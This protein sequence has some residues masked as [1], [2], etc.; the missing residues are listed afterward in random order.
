MAAVDANDPAVI[1][2]QNQPPAEGAAPEGGTPP[3]GGGLPSE[4]GNQEMSPWE[5]AKAEGLL[6][7]DFKEDAYE[8]AKSWKSGQEFVQEANAEKA[9]AGQ[10]AKKIE[11][12]ENITAEVNKMLPD[13]L[14]NG[15]ELT[16]EMEEKATELGVDIRDLK[17]GAIELR[18][19]I[20]AAHNI[21]GGQET[22]DSMIADM[23]EVMSEAQQAEF[24]K[25]VT[26]GMSEWA[27][28]GLYAEWK[29]GG[30]TPEGKGR[31]E[32]RVKGGSNAKPYENQHELLADLSYLRTKG[33][34]DKAAWAQHEKRK[35]AT[36]DN[37]VYGR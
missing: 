3:E 27:I 35:A 8:L 31:I 4:Q 16:P 17:L 30:Q 23:R 24:D 15:M 33:K 20:T 34:N 18:D 14:A 37:I 28:K 19:K 9:R 29:R 2:A 10:E 11:Q 26:G 25:A 36:P 13:F 12:Q 32:G 5:R 22:Y 7:E 1:E 21:V 6:P